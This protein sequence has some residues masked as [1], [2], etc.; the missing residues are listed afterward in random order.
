MAELRRLGCERLQVV[1]VAESDLARALLRCGFVP[2]NETVPLFAL[3]LTPLGEECVQSV[4]LW[5]IT[6]LECDR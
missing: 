6:D 1:A 3:P 4:R 2:R 5:E